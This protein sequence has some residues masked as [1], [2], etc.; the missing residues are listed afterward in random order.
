MVRNF[1]YLSRAGFAIAAHLQATQDGDD[2]DGQREDGKHARACLA[3]ADLNGALAKSAVSAGQ[4]AGVWRDAR[5]CT[6]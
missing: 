5:H 2:D 6:E 1:Q 4:F 3:E